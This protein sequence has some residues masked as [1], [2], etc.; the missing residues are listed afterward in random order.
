MSL[1]DHRLPPV[2]NNPVPDA[3][4]ERL[5]PHEPDTTRFAS[6]ELTRG[7]WDIG[8]QHG[9]PPAAL[10]GHEIEGRRSARSD[11]RVARMTVDIFRPVPI[12]VL[13]VA[14]R[15][16]HASRSIEVVDATLSDGDG[17]GDGRTLARASAVRIRVSD[18]PM[19]E[20][21]PPGPPP[22]IEPAE[23]PDTLTDFHFE[24]GYHTAMETRYAVGSFDEQGPATVWFRMRYPLVAGEPIQPLSRV[25]IAADS[26]NGVSHAID[27]RTH[28]FVNPELTVHLH[29]YPAGEFVCLD[30]ATTTEADGIGL[31]DTLLSDELGRIGRGTQALFIGARR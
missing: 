1:S 5:E 27:F 15:V 31:A 26:G 30:A 10:L 14:T 4:Y 17:D 3:F 12:G 23:L 8:S 7:P 22:P 16:A 6:T 21:R 19:P 18:V 11:M 13:A 20:R 28:V 2:Q 9:G 24:V 25:L 29:R